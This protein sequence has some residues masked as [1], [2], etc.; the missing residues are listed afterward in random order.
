MSIPH[1]ASGGTAPPLYYLAGPMSAP[2][3]PHDP[4][5]WSALQTRVEYASYV[6]GVLLRRGIVT[7]N[8]F[9]S[10]VSRHNWYGCPQDWYHGDLWLLTLLDGIVLLPG[11]RD[12]KG[13]TEH[14]LPFAREHQLSVYEWNSLDDTLKLLE[15]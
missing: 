9:S 8:P 6:Q 12:S 14:E 4:V 7:V 5:A 13:V 2:G 1:P 11:W 15:D 10:C 3:L